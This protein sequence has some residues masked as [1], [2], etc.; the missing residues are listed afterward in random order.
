MRCGIFYAGFFI[1]AIS[2]APITPLYRAVPSNLPLISTSLFTII[3]IFG[4]SK[5]L[6]VSSFVMLSLLTVT[7]VVSR[8]TPR[9]FSL[10]PKSSSYLDVGTWGW[11]DCEL[12]RNLCG[13]GRWEGIG[14]VQAF[15]LNVIH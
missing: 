1:L 13:P 6:Y 2:P 14:K 10:E 5:S 12:Y 9:P 8:D 3:A 4:I 11:L 15:S 7:R